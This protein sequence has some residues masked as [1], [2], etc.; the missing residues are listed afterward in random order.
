MR[1]A[2][3]KE[4][5]ELGEKLSF[6][7]AAREMHVSQSA[8]SKHLQTLEEDLGAKLVDRDRHHVMLTPQGELFLAKARAIVDTYEEAQQTF[9]ADAHNQHRLVIGGLVDSPMCYSWLSRSCMKMVQ[10]V[11]DFS[12]H[13]VPISSVAPVAQITEGIVDCAILNYAPT[14]YP[15]AV[16]RQLEA[17][18]VATSPMYA[19]VSRGSSLAECER[20]E[21]MDLQGKRFI[22]LVSPRTA[23]G[24]NA[25]E[26]WLHRNGIAFSTR[27]IQI[28]SAFDVMQ[29]PL[30]E[31]I[32]LM[33]EHDIHF[34]LLKDM[35]RIAIPIDAEFP[36]TS[37]DL[38]YR[39]GEDSA[40]MR[41]FIAN[42][43]ETA[44]KA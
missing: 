34:E 2:Y 23:S 7:A 6:S 33:P 32:L 11:P 38:V 20:L 9:L 41:A 43:T 16:Q 19:I 27:D 40:I 17:V 12:A 4:F 30:S 14:D 25:M 24:W 22:R 3:I 21:A 15:E 42:L 18:Q 31:D 44:V 37:V 8:L 26:R 5:I 10:A 35:D 1:I 28:F 36:T 13:F 39:A 29:Q